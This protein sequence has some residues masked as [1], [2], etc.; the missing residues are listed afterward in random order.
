MYSPHFTSP[1]YNDTEGAKFEKKIFSFF[2]IKKF[3]K[4]KR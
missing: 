3:F 1:G 2:N 4:R